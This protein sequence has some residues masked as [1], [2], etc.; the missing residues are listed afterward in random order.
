MH[1]I[2]HKIYLGGYCKYGFNSDV[3]RDKIFMRQVL[4]PIN[5]FIKRLFNQNFIHNLSES[6]DNTCAKEK[7]YQQNVVLRTNKNPGT[8]EK[9]LQMYIHRNSL[10]FQ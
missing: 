3:V 10:I 6:T 9:K 1:I 7:L 5:S 8:D 2:T 4:L